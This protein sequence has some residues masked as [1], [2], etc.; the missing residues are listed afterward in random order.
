MDDEAIYAMVYA[1]CLQTAATLMDKM[2]YPANH[3]N[4]DVTLDLIARAG[5]IFEMA[6]EEGQRAAARKGKPPPAR[7]VLWR[8][9]DGEWAPGA[10]PRFFIRDQD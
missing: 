4:E 2:K 3:T 8:T 7:G 5:T 9:V 6:L 1:T 10:R